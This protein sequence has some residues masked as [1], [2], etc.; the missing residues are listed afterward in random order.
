M[1]EGVF[2]RE[3]IR[4]VRVAHDRSETVGRD[5]DPL[6]LVRLR[7][8]RRERLLKAIQR[9]MDRVAARIEPEIIARDVPDR[10]QVFEQAFGRETA[11][12][13]IAKGLLD[14]VFLRCETGASQFGRQCCRNRNR[15]IRGCGGNHEEALR[16]S[17]GY[18][19]G[20]RHEHCVQRGEPQPGIRVR[21]QSAAQINH[22]RPG[23]ARVSIR[24]GR[25]YLADMNS[26]NGSFVRIRDERPLP[27]GGFVLMGQQL[28]RVV[29]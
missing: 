21:P 22:G 19:I 4:R 10:A 7:V 29:Y 14:R 6:D 11:S 18:A 2:G 3:I 26:S 13:Q 23:S 27:S 16:L 1:R 9:R 12:D 20:R 28:F 17:C 8:Q 5:V 24:D 25:C 15:R